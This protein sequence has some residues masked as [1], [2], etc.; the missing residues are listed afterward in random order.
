[1]IVLH[2]DAREFV[3]YGPLA[4][5]PRQIQRLDAYRSDEVDVVGAAIAR[6]EAAGLVAHRARRAG[7]VV[8]GGTSVDDEDGIRVYQDGFSIS[9]QDEGRLCVRVAGLGQTT[10]T[11]TVR[12]LDDAVAAVLHLR[13]T[14][15]ARPP[16]RHTGG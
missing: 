12:S 2:L 14:R 8:V 4:P 6:L 10:L 13:E 15:P 11:E 1:M 3:P 16:R 9:R 7:V 5:R